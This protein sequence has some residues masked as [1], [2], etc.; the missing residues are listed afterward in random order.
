MSPNPKFEVFEGKDGQWYVRLRARN[1]E[2]VAQ[3]EGYESEG[4]AREAP[5]AIVEAAMSTTALFLSGTLARTN[6]EMA[7]EE[8][9]VE[10]VEP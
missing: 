5:Q 10:T 3:S 9:R 7:I 8:S 4:A 6:D 1:G 2:I